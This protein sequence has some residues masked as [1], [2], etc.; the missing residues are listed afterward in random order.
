MVLPTPDALSATELPLY[1]VSPSVTGTS[2]LLLEGKHVLH[3]VRIIGLVV[4]VDQAPRFTKYTV[5]DG[6]ST[7]VC[8]QWL[9]SPL[10]E[11]TVR[12][13]LPLATLVMVEGRVR[14]Y[15]GLREIVVQTIGRVHDPNDEVL[16]W[17]QVIHNHHEYFTL[18]PRQLIPPEAV[19]FLNETKPPA[20]TPS[21]PGLRR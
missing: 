11:S 13:C 10:Q 15:Q 20:S 6:T 8:I 3:Y 2:L 17:L 14:D 12:T 4:A 19:Q 1:G 18:S 7:I 21:A 16:H 9:V 5:D